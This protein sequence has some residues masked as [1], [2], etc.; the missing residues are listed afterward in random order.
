MHVGIHRSLR[1]ISI[2]VLVVSGI[3]LILISPMGLRLISTEKGIN[4]ARLSSI[5]QTY[6]A[7]SAVI[8]GVALAGIAVS[9][10]FQARELDLTREQIS[11]NYHFDLIRFSLENPAFI[12][13]WGY[14]PAE[15]ASLDD[16][17]RMGYTNM[18]V[19][20]WSTSYITRSLGESELRLNFAHMFKGEVGRNYWE[21]SRDEWREPAKDRRRKKFFNIADAEYRK[22]IAA[23]PAL[24]STHSCQIRRVISN[25]VLRRGR[26][27]IAE[28]KLLPGSPRDSWPAL[29]C[30][31]CGI[32]VHLSPGTR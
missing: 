20:F 5:G 21:R 12:S 32:S 1:A 22:A 16:V 17:R 15:G 6:G 7:I 19:S 31:F 23:G 25:P 26:A 14:V 29:R 10:F 30:V 2:V 4:W 13:S 24:V 11:R 18:I 9:L 28:Q 3:F 27:T 8:S